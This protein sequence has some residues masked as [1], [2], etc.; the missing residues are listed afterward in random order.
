MGPR[1]EQK[2]HGSL[3]SSFSGKDARCARSALVILTDPSTRSRLASSRQVVL[4][5]HGQPCDLCLTRRASRA[6]EPMTFSS[7]DSVRCSTMTLQTSRQ[8][9]DNGYRP[10]H[11]FSQS[12]IFE[13]AVTIMDFRQR[14]TTLISQ[15]THSNDF[16]AS[17][18]ISMSRVW[19]SNY[20]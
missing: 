5:I 2:H 15:I 7:D 10:L 19:V 1:L 11:V 14:P 16:C 18:T 12:P 3:P 20:S 17:Q 8:T 4:W 9:A 6:S 13:P